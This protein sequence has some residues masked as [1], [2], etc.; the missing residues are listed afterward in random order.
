MSSHSSC[1]AIIRNTAGTATSVVA[2]SRSTSR[3]MRPGSTS[4]LRRIRPP[5]WKNGTVRTFH[6]PVW[7][8]GNTIGVTSS[9]RSPHAV[10]VLNAFQRIAPWLITVSFGVPVE[11]PV[12]KNRC[13]SA[14][15][16]S[17]VSTGEPSAGRSRVYGR[18]ASSPS[19]G[20]E[21]TAG[22]TSARSNASMTSPP[23]GA[24]TRSSSGSTVPN[25]AARSR[26]ASRCDS[27]ASTDPV[28]PVAKN[29]STSSTRFRET[30]ATR[31]PAPTPASRRKRAVRLARS[32]SSA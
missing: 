13:G 19:V 5:I 28:F 7:N 25:T 21:R 2:D 31:S 4:G 24:S 9:S 14:S 20:I 15:D 30:T 16:T 10:M 8:I 1:W 3:R 12:C 26:S 22:S 32:S 6:P 18:Q 23:N 17:A 29:R 11:P 27:G